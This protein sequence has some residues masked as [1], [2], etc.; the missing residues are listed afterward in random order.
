MTILKW[1][2]G[3][4]VRTWNWREMIGFLLGHYCWFAQGAWNFKERNQKLLLILFV[5]TGVFARSW[6]GRFALKLPPWGWD[7][8]N[9][10][11]AACCSVSDDLRLLRGAWWGDFALLIEGVKQG[12][13]DR[14][15]CTCICQLYPC[16][17]CIL[18]ERNQL[19]QR[20]NFCYYFLVWMVAIFAMEKPLNY[21]RGLFLKSYFRFHWMPGKLIGVMSTAAR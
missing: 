8:S 13:N 12:G 17:F 7:C 5:V 4:G 20:G 9:Y 2:R 18:G 16:N 19:S 14:K 10:L 6:V 15:D 21:F 11:S 3:E 1:A